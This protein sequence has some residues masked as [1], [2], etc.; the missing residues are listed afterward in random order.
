[1]AYTAYS[2]E[3]LV[4]NIEK[5]VNPQVGVV[6]INVPHNPTGYVLS[7]EQ[8]ARINHAVAPYDCVLAVDMVYAL[9]AL[10]PQAIQALGGLDADRTIYIDSF[11]KKFGLPGYRLGFALCANTELVEA[12]RMLKAA[13]SIST[14]NVKLLFAAHLLEHHMELAEATALE[15]RRRHEVFRAGLEGI[16]EYGIEVPP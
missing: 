9:H 8:V 7:A 14:S 2:A 15:I 16:E 6:M 5:L 10:E 4:S 3:E 11:S 1:M 12:L 13:E